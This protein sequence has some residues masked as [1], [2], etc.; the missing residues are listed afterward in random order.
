[1]V[2]LLEPPVERSGGFFQSLCIVGLRVA[3]TACAS[4]IPTLR[5][6]HQSIAWALLLVFCT[7]PGVLPHRQSSVD[8]R[9]PPAGF[10][11]PITPHLDG[12]NVDPET[13][14][15][16]GLARETARIVL[17]G[18]KQRRSRQQNHRQADHR[19]C[20]GWRA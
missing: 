1:M 10:C 2:H 14:R 6:A 11:M 16:L 5:W 3:A 20:Q 18:D 15:V 19:T 4:T 8:R 9:A 7:V 17:G 13:K 12:F